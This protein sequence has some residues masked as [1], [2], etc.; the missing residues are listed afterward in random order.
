MRPRAPIV[1]IATGA[2][3]RDGVHAFPR[4]RSGTRQRAGGRLAFAHSGEVR[5]H[6]AS[7]RVLA[8][9][10]SV[11]DPFLDRDRVAAASRV[12]PHLACGVDS[13]LSRMLPHRAAARAAREP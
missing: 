10:L 11:A 4:M 2:P 8:P 1:G 13:D 5:R 7:R 12:A 9:D 6:E 3:G